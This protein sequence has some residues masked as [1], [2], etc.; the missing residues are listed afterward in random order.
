MP[1]A[2][3]VRTKVDAMR[4]MA[5]TT[6]CIVATEAVLT[7]AQAIFL[8]GHFVIEQTA[9]L[10]RQAREHRAGPVRALYVGDG[11]FAFAHVAQHGT[12]VVAEP[13][14]IGGQDRRSNERLQVRTSHKLWHFI[15]TLRGWHGLVSRSLYKFTLGCRGAGLERRDELEFPDF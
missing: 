6:L 2:E 14:E 3:T 8:D 12:H 1:F 10:P 5:N 9:L 11:A 7:K 13:G 15:A 4:E